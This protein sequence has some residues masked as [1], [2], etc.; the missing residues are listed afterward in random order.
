[1]LRL[2]AVPY[3]DRT[4]F[5]CFIFTKEFVNDWSVEQTTFCSF[6]QSSL[7]TRNVLVHQG[8]FSGPTVFFIPEH[9]RAQFCMRAF[10]PSHWCPWRHRQMRR[11]S[12]LHV[13]LNV[14]HAWTTKATCASLNNLTTHTTNVRPKHRNRSHQQQSSQ[15]TQ[16]PDVIAGRVLPKA[17]E[18][19][20]PSVRCATPLTIPSS[21]RAATGLTVLA[22]HC[23]HLSS[24]HNIHPYKDNK[25]CIAVVES[26]AVIYE[27]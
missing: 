23:C 5:Q 14:L 1:L 27:H 16:S 26:T 15:N 25:H 11:L 12:F 6:T 8:Y 24:T 18:E 7:E 10:Q 13:V 3:Q 4:S 19:S 9:Q 20:F 21:L 2:P 22:R 17:V